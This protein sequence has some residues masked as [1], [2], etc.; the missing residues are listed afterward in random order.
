MGKPKLAEIVISSSVR[1][2]VRAKV[3][4][5]EHAWQNQKTET[6]RFQL[7]FGVFVL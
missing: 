6:I 7:T 4:A 2:S 3:S 1:M 5:E